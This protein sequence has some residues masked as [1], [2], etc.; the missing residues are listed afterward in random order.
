MTLYTAT[1]RRRAASA[2]AERVAARQTRLNALR[3]TLRYARRVIE[4][5]A[6]QVAREIVKATCGMDA[7]PRRWEALIATV[8]GMARQTWIEYQQLKGE[9]V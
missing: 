9:P 2:H 5:M 7:N 8:A 4:A 6:K 3:A 1:A